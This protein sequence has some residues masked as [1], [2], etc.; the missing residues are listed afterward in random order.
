MHIFPIKEIIIKKKKKKIS[1]NKYTISYNN[2]DNIT[3]EDSMEKD[4]YND[5][6]LDKK[7]NKTY[8]D[9]TKK[10]KYKGVEVADRLNNYGIYLK[11][12]IE[13]Q[14]QI[15]DNKIMQLMKPK[16]RG[17]SGNTTKNPE[18]ISERLYQDY[19]KNIDKNNRNNNTKNN[20]NNTSGNL[21]DFTYYFL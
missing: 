9:E 1:K 2:I 10:I 5:S 6:L 12:K 19:K 17:K 21:K 3:K 13:N 4:K 7:S 16:K 18:K 20:L 8:N 11:N 15:Q 14:R